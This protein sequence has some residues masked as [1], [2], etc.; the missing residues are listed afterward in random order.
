MSDLNGQMPPQGPLRTLTTPSLIQAP[1]GA[2]HTGTLTL[3][4]SGI[5]K[6]LYLDQGRVV[7]AASTDP[8]DRLGQLYLRHGMISLSVLKEGATA[9]LQ[10]KKRLGAWLVEQKAIRA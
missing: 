9:S 3:E 4:D 1:C 2:R 5:S 8:E 6:T 7:F 10:T